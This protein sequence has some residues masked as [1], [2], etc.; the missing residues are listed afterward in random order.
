MAKA[1]QNKA[2]EN[3]INDIISIGSERIEFEKFEKTWVFRQLTTTEHVDVITKSGTGSAAAQNDMIAR[4]YKMQVETLKA[5]IVSING[6][7]L[8]IDDADV[9]FASVSPA[10]CDAIYLEFE[11]R[12]AAIERKFTEVEKPEVKEEAAATDEVVDEAD[13]E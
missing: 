4:L 1:K 6:T 5:A 10:V 11:N 7:E 9:L 12:R 3:I 8:S 2:V 13:A